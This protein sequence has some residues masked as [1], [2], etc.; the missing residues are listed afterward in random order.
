MLTHRETL[1]YGW[2]YGT[3]TKKLREKA[4]DPS[5]HINGFETAASRPVTASVLMMNR[6]MQ[7][8][9]IDHQLEM[10]IAQAYSEITWVDD[11]PAEQVL[12]LDLQGSWQLGYYRGVNGAPLPA[13]FDAHDIAGQRRALGLSQAELASRVGVS[14]GQVSRWE[15]GVDTP[16]EENLLKLQE[17]FAKK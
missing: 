11:E 13:P 12:P 9:I 16:T 6:A 14:Q 3:I 1:I 4:H 7:E 15:R 8:H 17:V 5:L 10:A 2:V